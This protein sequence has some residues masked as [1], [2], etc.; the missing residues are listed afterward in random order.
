M[1]K[2]AWTYAKR[3]KINWMKLPIGEM[4]EQIVDTAVNSGFFSIWMEVFKDIPVVKMKLIEKF[5]GIADECFDCNCL[6]Q[7]RVN[8]QL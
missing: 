7:R 8:G 1:R 3:A 2:D 4:A 6:P 5:T